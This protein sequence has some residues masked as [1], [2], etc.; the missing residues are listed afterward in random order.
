[1][2]IYL[3]TNKL[4][5]TGVQV[6]DALNNASS[7]PVTN[8]AVTSALSDGG[9]VTWQKP[10]D[11]MDIRNGAFNNSVYFLVAHSE[12]V[13]SEGTYTISQYPKWACYAR[14]QEGNTYDIFVDGVK[15][16]TS[17]SESVTT[18]DWAQLYTD[19]TI[20]GGYSVTTPS[21]LITHIVRMAPTNSSDTLNAAKTSSITG[22]TDHGLLWAHFETSTPMWL[23]YA[24]GAENGKRNY[25]LQAITA[26][27][28][29]ITYTVSATNNQSGLRYFAP[30]CT[31]LVQIPVLEAESTAYP[32]ANYMCFQQVPAKKVVIKNNNGQENLALLNQSY[33]ETFDIE[34][35]IDFATS[36]TG[37]L[38]DGHGMKN[39]KT[40]PSF[41]ES[42]STTFQVYGLTS[43][44]PTVVDDSKN[45]SR[46]MFRFFG[47][48]SEPVVGLKGLTVSS[49]APF[50]GTSP[51]IRVDYTGMDRVALVKLFKSMPTVSASQV[52]NV[53]GATGANDLT[54]QDLAIATN[55]GW[56]VTR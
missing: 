6:D 23:T 24:F 9:Y 34:N 43:L 33:V 14:I 13:L 51:Q 31:S 55:K 26:K 42:Q 56:T 1:M 3:G 45:S 32:S 40:L 52:C 38:Q 53:T 7:N 37:T 47:T 15:V 44:E 27:N 46:T 16:A 54:A 11:W 48:S 30:Y 19:G 5:G 41:N 25:L 21:N 8:S 2:A 39:L 50:T 4:T 35:G 18:I 10:S 12:P 17:A 28:N 22:Q 20:M 29:K 36:A 49:S